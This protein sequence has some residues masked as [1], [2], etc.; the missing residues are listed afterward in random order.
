MI[1]TIGK[2]YTLPESI[3]Q[4]FIPSTRL[5]SKALVAVIQSL[6]SSK[7]S[8]VWTLFGHSKSVAII[9]TKIFQ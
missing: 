8:A 1:T 2:G 7:K 5:L 4:F 6:D 3:N 9:Q